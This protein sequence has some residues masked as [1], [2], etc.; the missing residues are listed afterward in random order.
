M[1]WVVVVVAVLVL[2]TVVLVLRE[3][4]RG[5]DGKVF[6]RRRSLLFSAAERSFLGALDLATGRDFR[7]FGKVRV[8]D[9]LAPQ[10]GLGSSARMAAL[11]KINRK[12]FD[13]V[14]CRPNDLSV[15]CVIELNDRSH[16]NKNRQLRDYFLV[17][18][19][20]GAGLPLVMFDARRVY[21]PSEIGARIAEAIAEKKA[22]Y[23]KPPLHAGETNEASFAQ[24]PDTPPRCPRC[25]SVMVRRTAKGGDNAGKP[26]WGCPK[27]PRCREIV[28]E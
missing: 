1:V 14:L 6:Y 19:C 26:F 23:S 27:F 15:L 22:V 5:L 18:A 3:R 12:H 25:A 7:I 28:A 9:L 20:E 2:I 11:N 16:Q 10:D 4:A 21:T 8:G 17:D 24:A 13:F